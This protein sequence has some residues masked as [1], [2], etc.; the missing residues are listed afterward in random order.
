VSFL[1]DGAAYFEALAGAI[2]RAEQSVAMVGW[3]FHSRVRLRRSGGDEPE[4]AALLDA[5]ARRGVDVYLL[6]WDFAVIYALERE[7]LPLLRFGLTTHP[8]VR[9]E[10]DDTHPLAGSHHQKIAVIDDRVAFCGGIDVTA[11]RWDTPEHRAGDPRR[12]DPGFPDYGPFHDV[13]MAVDGDAAAALGELVRERW[14][15][16]TGERPSAPA[17]LRGDP[18]PPGLEPE[19]RDVAVGIVRT[20]PPYEGQEAVREVEALWLESVRAARRLIYIENQYLTAAAVGDALAER[21]RES[22][23]PEVVIVGPLACSGWLEEGAMGVMR[24]RLLRRLR[25]ADRGGRLHVYHPVLPGVKPEDLTVHSKVLVV[26]DRLLRIGSANLSNRSMGLDSECDLAVAS[27][28][29]DAVASC[30]EALRNRLLAE[31]LD[32]KPAEVAEARKEAGSWG[33]AIERLG[34]KPR[35][36]QPFDGEVPEWLDR[37]VPETQLLDPEKPV[38]LERLLQQ[39]LPEPLADRGGRSR[40]LQLGLGVLALALLAL[41]WRVTPLS[42]LASAERLAALAAPLRGSWTGSVLALGAFVLLSLLMVPV[43]ALIVS[44]A[45]VFDAAGGFAVALAG[46]LAS[47]A[48]GYALGAHLWQDVVRRLAGRRLERLSRALARR[49][50][51]SVATVRLVPIAPFTV[52]NLVAGASHIRFPDFLLGTLLGMGP[53]IAVLCLLSEGAVRA[54]RDPS[55]GVWLGLLVLAALA[56]GGGLLLRRYLVRERSHDGS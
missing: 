4:F 34:G 40:L 36:L 33:A 39:M 50:A 18:W 25:E 21:L 42:E 44:C 17:P 29:G 14:R 11:S 16:A 2:E 52:V 45:L 26:D 20:Q 23:G 19:L 56:A 5:A 24:A 31:H 3:D 22:D 13:Q 27:R 48:A 54:F 32:A 6:G 8:R 10:L 43:T 38:D 46:S 51:A 1:I 37:L 9:F 49:G 53:G 7:A 47:A 35:S 55:S 30:I 15:H 41:V 12:S 28:G